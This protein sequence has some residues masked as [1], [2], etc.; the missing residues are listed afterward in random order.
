[1]SS[2]GDLESIAEK[3][4]HTTS[5]TP[6]WSDASSNI[7]A[8]RPAPCQNTLSAKFSRFNG[9]LERLSGFEIR[10]ISRV[11]A[12]ERH[13]GSRGHDLQIFLLWLSANLS[14]NNLGVGMLGP[15]AYGLGFKDCLMCILV[16]TFIGSLSTA[17][18]ATF[19]PLSGNRT[20]VSRL[21]CSGYWPPKL[22]KN[23]YQVVARFFMGYWPSKIPCALNVVLMAGYAIIDAILGGQIISAVSGGSVS[24]VVGIIIVS[25]LAWFIAV[26]G[27]ALFQRY[28]RLVLPIAY[29]GA[30]QSAQTLS[31]IVE[32]CRSADDTLLTFA[33]SRYS[34]L[35][36]ILALMVLIGSAAPN[37][38]TESQSTLT[39]GKLAAARLTFLSICSYIPNSWTAAAA[40]FYVYY[41]ENTKRTKVFCL[42]VAGLFVSFVT[43]FT[44]GMGLAS[45]VATNPAWAAANDISSGALLVEGLAP[46]KGFGKFIGVVIALGVIGNSTPSTY[47][48][49]LSCQALGRYGQAVPRWAWACVLVTVELIL[50]LAGRDH[51]FAIYQ[52]FT[53]IMGYWI[54]LMCGIF[55]L[56]E[57]LFR[58]R[59]G[60]CDWSRWDDRSYLPIG[61]AAFASFLLGWMGAVLGMNQAWYVGPI[62]TLCNDADMGMWLGFLFTI[63]SFIPLRHL[64]LKMV[65]R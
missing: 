64:E 35:P 12:E 34:W 32:R 40:D 13:K 8:Q 10:G 26:F 36:Q 14:A 54:E 22:T 58:R 44:I 61:W 20:M 46:L 47:S 17:Y 24:I 6:T 43:V 48:G 15:L 7:H 18:V 29:R 25:L 51:L 21:T 42:T 23:S 55:L 33:S 2:H 16:G 30:A 65:G 63:V 4:H 39:G 3:G 28:E 59:K 27:M 45:G 62:S 52:N 38:D 41:P 56:E 49:A 57:F 11:P 37:F 53:S 9:R 50:G 5:T 60:Q 31:S 1:M 19:G